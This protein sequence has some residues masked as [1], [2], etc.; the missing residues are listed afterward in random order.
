VHVTEVNTYKNIVLRR[1]RI[2]VCNDQEVKIEIESK[3]LI[4]GCG[5]DITFHKM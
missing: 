4:L 2:Y 1:C 5:T 3:T